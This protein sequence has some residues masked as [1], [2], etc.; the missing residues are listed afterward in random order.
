MCSICGGEY[1]LEVVRRASKKMRHRGPD[2]SGE[3][4]KGGIA[5]AHNRLS[6]IDLDLHANQPFT[7]PLC[8]HLVLVFNGEIYNYLEIKSD[9]EK[10]GIPFFT[11]SDTEVLLHAFFHYGAESLKKFN[12]DFAFC[13]LDVR[14]NSLFLARDRL[15]NKPLFYTLHNNKLFFASEIKAFFALGKFPFDYDEVS[16]WI[17]FGCGDE[18]K[19]IY[20]GILNFPKAHF[21]TYKGGILKFSKYWDFSPEFEALKKPFN[22][23]RLDSSLCE[24]ESLLQ[25]SL[26]IRLRSDVPVA[27][28]VSG[29]VDSSILAHLAI[30]LNANCELFGINFKENKS[31]DESKHLAQLQ[32]DLGVKINFL[33]P[34]LNSIKSDFK[35]LVSTQ[36]E[37]T[38]SL[39]QYAQFLLF[40]EIAKTHKVA[41]GGQG[42]DELFGGYYHHVGRFIYENFSEFENRAFIYGQEAFREYNFGLKCALKKELKLKLF[43]NDN[44]KGL[45]CLESLGLPLPSLEPLLERF[46]PSFSCGLWLDLIKFNLPHL[47]RYEDRN[48]MNFGLENRTPFTDFRLV[49]FAFKINENFKFQKG[50]SKYIL[51]LLLE[52]LG[53]FKLAWRTDKIGFCVPE[54]ELLKTLGIKAESLFEVRLEIFRELKR[55]RNDMD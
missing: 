2:F 42:A 40:C 3:F 28:S 32:E 18:V 13:I 55:V 31:G 12:G 53:S 6:I 22:K 52:K 9:L 43:E 45:A 41:L 50:F 5:L 34:S 17:L 48:S 36:D 37:I 26:K 4:S 8:P 54:F 49:E 1:G 7:S 16:K 20:S 25:D 29:G 11:K 30:R 10:C 27:L 39:S 15:G 14:D 33:T 35:K 24:L 21:A 47:L 46:H 44:K 19:T 38:H 51:R 23:A